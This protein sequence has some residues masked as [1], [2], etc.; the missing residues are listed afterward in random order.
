MGEQAVR[1]DAQATIRLHE[2]METIT[3]GF[4]EVMETHDERAEERTD[5]LIRAVNDLKAEL[6]RGKRAE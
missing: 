5:A 6:R 2:G 4:R 1:Q 3:K